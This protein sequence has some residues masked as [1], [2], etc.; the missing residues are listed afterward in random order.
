MSLVASPVT[1]LVSPSASLRSGLVDQEARD[2]I[3]HDL[4]TTL[5]VEAAAGTGKTTAL[6]GRVL[7]LLET[8]RATLASLVAVTF[9]EKAASEMKFRLRGEIEKALAQ[10]PAEAQA[11]NLRRARHELEIARIT[12]I[13]GL[14]AELLRERPIEARVD[15]LFTVASEDDTELLFSECFERWFHDVLE[16]PPESIARVLRRRSKDSRGEGPRDLLRSDALRLVDQRDF[17]GPWERRPFDRIKAI[18]DI[19][20]E[21]RVLGQFAKKASDKTYLVEH[22]EKVARAMDEIARREAVRGRDYDGLE[23]ELRKLCKERSWNWQG[24]RSRD[25]GSGLLRADIVAKRDAVKQKLEDVL[26]LVDADLASKLQSDLMPL[27]RQYEELKAQRGLIDFLDLLTKTRD[28]LV[29]SPEVRALLAQRTTHVLVDEFQDTDPTQAEILLLLAGDPHAPITGGVAEA[30]V[31]APLPGKLFV[32]G[33]PKQSIYRFRRADMGFYESVKTRLVDAGARV[34]RLSTSFRSAPSLQA[35]ANEA[36]R[37]LMDGSPGQAQ[38]VDLAPIRPEPPDH[39]TI[40]ALPI[41]EPYSD[42]GKVTN[43]SIDTSCPDA[44]GAFVDWLVNESGYTVEEGGQRV[45][46]RPGHIAFLFKRLTAFG[47]DATRPYVR[48]LESRKIAH[49]L[50]GGRS[51]YE[52]EEVLALKNVLAAI[53]WPDDEL[54]VYATLK[55]PFFAFTDEELLVHRVASNGSINPLK[56]VDQTLLPATAVPVAGALAFLGSLHRTRNRRPI[57]DTIR[58]FLEHTR[59]HAGVAIWPAGEQALAN[60]LRFMEIARHFELRRATSFR[61]FLRKLE[62]DADRGG[63]SEATLAE[64]GAEGV[65]MLTV[66]KAKGL[67]FPVVVLC[68]PTA[69]PTHKEPSRFVNAKEKKWVTPL[70]FCSPY[71]LIDEAN[72]ARLLEEDKAESHRLL[73]V[74]ATRAKEMLV[75]P[76]CGDERLPDSWQAPLHPCVYPSSRMRRRSGEAPFVPAGFGEDSVLKRGNKVDRVTEDSVRPGLHQPELPNA[77]RVTWWDPAKLVLEKEDEAGLRQARILA[78]DD[79]GRADNSAREHAQWK[80]RMTEART[81]GEEPAVVLHTVTLDAKNARATAAP[82]V[83]VDLVRASGSDLGRDGR[84]RVSG[85]LFGTLVHATLASAPFDAKPK[86]LAAIALH[87]AR[88]LGAPEELC[89]E[90]LARVKAALAHELMREAARAPR[91]M[92]EVPITTAATQPSRDVM[93]GVID[94]AYGSPTTGWTVVDFKTDADADLTR[95]RDAYEAQVRTYCGALTELTGAPARGVLFVV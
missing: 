48:A 82:P 27:V 8:G 59:A 93:D 67:E 77:P 45:P 38:Y 23:S 9:T 2:A 39:P 37:P 70:C 83:T 64:E 62:R 86:D 88:M 94:L 22:L 26:A 20:D 25:Y 81:R 58:T 92:R 15:P 52:R 28:L 95:S 90:A 18:D 33:D 47:E 19:L 61:A 65:R 36:F 56:P 69:P 29:H 84:A 1:G 44:V 73:Y 75:L 71:E 66:H 74:A 57:P 40:V 35:F 89:A 7:A 14:C 60:V 91:I 3:A 78:A 5:V 24:G 54:S 16:N 32:V 63:T 21:L 87:H 49:V 46:L 17:D 76:V 53:E 42:Y 6:V 50:V 10:S 13:H 34:L 51:F 68:D 31:L 79:G 12:T 41:P 72:R 43:W 80:T 4:D 11:I 30:G 85:R 55:G